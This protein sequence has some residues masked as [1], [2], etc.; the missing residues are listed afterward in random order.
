MKT[1]E[2]KAQEYADSIHPVVLPETIIENTV[3]DLNKFAQTDYLAGY[4]EAMRW[5]DPK[6]E[7]PEIAE[8]VFVKYRVQNGTLKYSLGKY[9]YIGK[10]NPW[11]IRGSSSGRVIGWKS[12]E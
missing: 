3:A 7:L 4:S 6:E 5:K 10:P 8:T 1:K 2:E 9:I 11:V 12:I